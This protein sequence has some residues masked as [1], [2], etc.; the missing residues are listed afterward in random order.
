MKDDDCVAFLQWALPRMGLYWPGFRKVRGL[1]CKRIDRRRRALGIDT[2]A[3]YRDLLRDNAVEWD[4]LRALCAIPISRFYRDRGVFAALEHVVLPGLAAAA[5]AR[6]EHTLSCW[7]VGC[8]SGEEAYTLSIVWQ[9]QFAAR[10]P[11]VALRILG[12]DVDPVLLARAAVGCYPSS[13]LS[14]LPLGL[15]AQAFEARARRHC[16]REKFRAGVVFEQRDIRDSIP[17]ARF[18]LVLCRNGVLTYFEPELQRSV[19]HRIIAT[20]RAGGALVV[21]VHESLP[22]GTEG[23]ARWPGMRCIFRRGMHAN[24]TR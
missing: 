19:L 18:D 12:S 3:G 5:C 4:A 22:A 16:V 1:V 9:L 23:L 21:G 24:G 20:L 2:V 17:D 14:E 11:A 10:F 7:S 15:R 8:A 6:P 13:S